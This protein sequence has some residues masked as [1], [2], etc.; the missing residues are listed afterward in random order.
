VKSILLIVAVAAAAAGLFFAGW[1]P[2]TQRLQGV[3]AEALAEEKETL[4]VTVAQARTSEQTA[5][6]TLPATVAGIRDTGVYARAEG[7]IRKLHV[8]IGDFVRAGQVLLEI[9]SPEQDQQ[10]RNARARLEQLKASAAQAQAA[11]KVAQANLKLAT[12]TSQ[13][14]L[15]LVR[16]GVVSRQQ[17]DEA[18]AQFEARQADVAVQQ[19]NINAAGQNVHAQEAEVSRLEELTRFQHVT[20]PFD[21]LITVR[22]CAVGNLI[23]PQ[24]IQQGRELYRLTDLT[25][26]RVFVN[27]PQANIASIAV[28]QPATVTVQEQPGREFTGVVKRTSNLLDAQTR[29]LLTE[30]NVANQGRALL[31][32]MYAQVTLRGQKNGERKVVL[33]PGDT[34][35]TGAK[36][37]QV[38]V[39]RGNRIQWVRIETGRDLGAE[40]EVAQGLNGGETVVVN[41]SDGVK[42]GRTV[43]SSRLKK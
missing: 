4:T 15:E 40:V 34:I 7:Y 31:P 28:G 33:V 1:A 42:E 36:G 6:L 24:S 35:V 22:N 2:R 20:A 21:G 17:G 38:A 27:T 37:T 19:A 14:V 25:T 12:A 3:S 41:P 9:D 29:T 16:Q 32:G 26:L 8:D 43:K 39:V 13:R 23:T 30:V 10:L 11:E 5:D 18:Q